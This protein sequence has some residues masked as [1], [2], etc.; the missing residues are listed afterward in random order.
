MP[1]PFS[2]SRVEAGKG[3]VPVDSQTITFVTGNKKKAEEVKRI[4]AS[5][6]SDFPYKITNHKVDLPELQGDPIFIAKEKAAL[7]AKEQT[8][9]VEFLR[10]F[11]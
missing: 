11:C 10:T 3:G 7:A 2:A 6:S 5:G 4:L 8:F 1:D 9:A